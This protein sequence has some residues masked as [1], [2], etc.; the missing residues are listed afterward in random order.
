M[1]VLVVALLAVLGLLDGAFSGFR[2]S[3][4]RTGLVDHSATD[5]EAAWY[6]ARLVAISMLP[7]VGA[8]ALD[9]TLSHRP[10]SQYVEAGGTFLVLLAPYAVLV[11]LALIGYAVTDWHRKYLASALIL[12]PFTLWRPYYVLAAATL[13]A[14]R[15]SDLTV[16]GTAILA[17]TAVLL[18]EPI[19]NR[20][21]AAARQ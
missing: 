5:R 20:R 10:T 8:F 3:L 4:G 19:A 1:I 13:A 16:T 7:A 2:A 6:G 14:L 17:T 11:I 18:V 12:G 21:Y 15:V 9:L